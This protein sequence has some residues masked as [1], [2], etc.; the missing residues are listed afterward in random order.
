M[1]SAFCVAPADNV[2]TLLDD[3]PPGAVEVIGCP[4][5][6]ST[7]CLSKTAAGHKLAIRDIAPGAPIVKYGVTIGL[8]TTAIRAGEL[9]HLHNCHSRLDERSST[10]DTH[11]GAPTDTRYA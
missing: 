3:A 4:D 10:L 2:V 1:P 5:T 7:L 8:A 11:T 6:A 9:V